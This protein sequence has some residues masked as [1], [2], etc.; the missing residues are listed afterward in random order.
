ML[1]RTQGTITKL[2]PPLSCILPL[3]SIAR[4][5]SSI[6]CSGQAVTVSPEPTILGYTDVTTEKAYDMIKQQEIVVLDV[7]TQEKFNSGYIPGTLLIPLSELESRLDEL[8]PSDHILVYCRSGHRSA[9]AASLLA[10]NG[11]TRVYNMVGGILQWQSQA[12]PVY[13]EQATPA[14]AE[15]TTSNY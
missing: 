12:F 13:T 6:S 11:F 3:I 5:A 4:L 7:R 8:N 2:R 15:P 10:A 1:E 14:S 9:E